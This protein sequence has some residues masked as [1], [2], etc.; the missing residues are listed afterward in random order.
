LRLASEGHA[1]ELYG[2]M[3]YVVRYGWPSSVTGI[4]PGPHLFVEAYWDEY[5]AEV[6]AGRHRLTMRT[7]D[8]GDSGADS[9]LDAMT[10]Y[11]TQFSQLNSGIID[12]LRNPLIR[13]YEVSWKVG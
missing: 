5:L 1:V 11:A 4:D 8:L 9:K 7:H 13:R 2:D 3:P 6:T 12:R 10:K